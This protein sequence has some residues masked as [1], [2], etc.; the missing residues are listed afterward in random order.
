MLFTMPSAFVLFPSRSVPDA[1]LALLFPPFGTTFCRILMVDV[2]FNQTE[3]PL[4]YL[5]CSALRLRLVLI[6]RYLFPLS[7]S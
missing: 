2:D 6:F 1:F 3:Y 7:A 4:I 5:F